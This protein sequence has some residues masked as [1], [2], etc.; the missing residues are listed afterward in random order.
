MS[1]KRRT[2]QLSLLMFIYRATIQF[3]KPINWSAFLYDLCLSPKL[4]PDLQKLPKSWPLQLAVSI[5]SEC[6]LKCSHWSCTVATPLSCTLKIQFSWLLWG[7]L[8]SVA[9][10]G[11]VSSALTG[12]SF[13]IQKQTFPK[14]NLFMHTWFILSV[15]VHLV[16]YL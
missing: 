10:A 6:L 13:E 4:Q 16:R 2:F 8:G 1:L 5:C 9:G 15:L 14:P 7:G 3:W 11:S 12:V